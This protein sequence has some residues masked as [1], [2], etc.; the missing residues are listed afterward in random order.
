MYCSH[1]SQE[2]Y[3]TRR[4]RSIVISPGPGHPQTDSGISRDVIKWA[5]GKVPLLGVCMGLEC[6]VDV[7]GGEVRMRI[8]RG[9][10]SIAIFFVR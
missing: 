2:L 7:M 10:R 1:N 9:E 6:V 3:T 4:L 8:Q 5:M